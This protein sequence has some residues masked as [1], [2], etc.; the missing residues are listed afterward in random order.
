MSFC[1][2]ESGLTLIKAVC[3]LWN[4]CLDKGMKFIYSYCNIVI[5]SEYNNAG[6]SD[7]LKEHLSTL[8]R[9]GLVLYGV[10]HVKKIE[11]NVEKKNEASMTVW[12]SI[13]F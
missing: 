7:G 13:H 8:K 11:V 1:S 4:P 9:G 10:H 5:M 6:L 3:D 12:Y 2:G